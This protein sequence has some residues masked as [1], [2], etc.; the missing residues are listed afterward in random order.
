MKASLL[1]QN[2]YIIVILF[3]SKYQASIH[4]K[5]DAKGTIQER[6]TMSKYVE[7]ASI[8]ALMALGPRP[9]VKSPYPILKVLRTENRVFDVKP[10]MSVC[11]SKRRV[12]VSRYQDAKAVLKDSETFTNGIIQRT[13]GVVMG[14]TVIGMDGKEHLKHRIVI[15]PSMTTRELKG[16]GLLDEVR[17][18][19][20][21]YID[22]FVNTG[23]ADLHEAFC[24]SFPLSVFAAL[25]GLDVADVK[26][27]HD[28]SKDLCL[29]AM[30]PEKGF[31][32]ST[33][34]LNLLEPVVQNKRSRPGNDIIS[35][36]V[37]AEVDGEKLTDLE[38]ISFLRLLT[39]VGAE[40]TN[41]TIGTALFA[42]LRDAP[43]MEPVRAE[44]SLVP[45]LVWEAMRWESPVSTVVREA[46]CDTCIGDTDIEPGTDVICHLGSANRDERQFQDA[47]TFDIYREDCDPIP[48][49]YGRHYCAGSHLAKLEAEIGLNALLDRLGNIQA[50]PV[51]EFAIVG[52]SFR[53][54]D[55][56]PV[57]FDKLY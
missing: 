16:S 6:T 45:N 31:A 50:I 42:L 8:D 28:Y 26:E 33:W 24:Y 55:R 30:D 15:T 1:A 5:A 51:E 46:S 48:V 34:L 47:D 17:K 9:A 4:A 41:H 56:I 13:M 54:R 3:Y 21:G 37:Q 43:L 39:L 12:L 32:A 7:P 10:A 27:F 44:R 19:A 2:S 49:G 14:P 35:I 11:G 57:S 36:L 29:V 53:V 22:K 52:F 25:L 38:V 18:I 23:S 20:D 40:M